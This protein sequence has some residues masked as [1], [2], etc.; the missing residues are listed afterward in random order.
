MVR[1]KAKTENRRLSIG[2]F[3]WI[4][5]GGVAHHF[6]SY[7]SG[8]RLDTQPLLKLQESLGN[9]VLLCDQ[10]EGSMKND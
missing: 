5:P 1:R 8:Y 4:E 6:C 10:E 2:I 9:A 3:K 7:S